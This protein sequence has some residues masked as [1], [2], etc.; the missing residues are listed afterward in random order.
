MDPDGLV[1]KL[2]NHKTTLGTHK[3]MYVQWTD[4][5]VKWVECSPMVQEI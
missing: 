4:S 1:A 2:S 5:L 3:Y